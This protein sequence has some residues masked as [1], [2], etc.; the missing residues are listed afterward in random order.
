M[1]RKVLTPKP[2]TPDSLKGYGG[3]LAPPSLDPDRGADGP[4]SG[5]YAETVRLSEPVAFTSRDGMSLALATLDPRPMEVR[6]ME[7]HNKHT[8]TFIPLDGK[9]FVMV[10]GRPTCRRPDGS[11]NDAAPR[12]PDLEKV[13]AFAFD[14]SAGLCLDIGAWHEFPFPLEYRTNIVVVMSEETKRDLKN[15]EDGEASGGD[16]E[17]LD[18]RKRFGVILEVRGRTKPS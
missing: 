4:E 15:V 6:W 7:Y 13:E 12:A 18:L 1:K 8:Q 16:L 5:F 14:G 3:L 10:L 2:A 17:K 11:W 9:P